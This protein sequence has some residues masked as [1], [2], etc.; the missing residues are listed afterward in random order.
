MSL[1]DMRGVAAIIRSHHERWDG[2]GFPDGL[3]GDAIPPGAR[4]LALANDYDAVQ[5]GTLSAKKLNSDEAK[6]YVIEG[7]GFRYDPAVCDAFSE[8]I[9]QRPSQAA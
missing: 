2:T 4:I 5:I 1:P 9:G 6:Q 3:K 8:L 7:R